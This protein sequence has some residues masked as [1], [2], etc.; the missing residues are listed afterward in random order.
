MNS[1][2]RRF[3]QHLS[4]EKN[5]SP[6]TIAAYEDDLRQFVE[7]LARHFSDTRFSLDAID[8]ITLRLF[9]G[10]LVE[11]RFSKRSI[12]RKLA[13]VKSFFAYLYKKNVIATNP[14]ANVR[15]PKLDKRLPVVL[16]EAEV[17][18]LMAQPDRTTPKG[19]RDAAILETFYS[20]GIRLG[21]LISLNL[22]DV[23]MEGSTMRVT[24]KGNKQRVVPFGRRAG[25]AL[26]SYMLVRDDFLRG[27]PA[28]IKEAVFLTPKG[29]RL[30]PKGVN[31]LM[32]IY[33]GRVS[34]ITKKSPHV[35]R[36]SFATHMLN[37]G[38]DLRAVK[39][40]LGHESL[41]TTQL[42]TH[43]SVHRLKSVYAQAHPK[44]S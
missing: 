31:C 20:T 33:I 19:L 22:R 40:L 42:Y 13:C 24:G 35:L 28:A 43:V 36:H 15:S 23:D 27:N 8:H 3:L 7:F 4:G 30:T 16:E 6:N 41:S 37:R 10:D 34:E 29:K 12:A 39:E 1:D 38:A 21:E 25:E 18:A 26:A 5:Y 32:N 44:A 14:A 9:L 2:V 11:Q 17:E